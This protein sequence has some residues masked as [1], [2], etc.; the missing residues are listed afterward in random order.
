MSGTVAYMN[1]FG[2]IMCDPDYELSIYQD[3]MGRGCGG[4][5]KGISARLADAWYEDLSDVLLE[6]IHND[7]NVTSG[8]DPAT[9]LDLTAAVRCTICG[10]RIDSH[11]GDVI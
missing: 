3:Q 9:W 7:I 6:E 8:I 11:G 4:P 10:A 2:E 5:W 1:G